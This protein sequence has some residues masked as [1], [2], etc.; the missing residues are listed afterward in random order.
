MIS[1]L[2]GPKTSKLRIAVRVREVVRKRQGE[3]KSQELELSCS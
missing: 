1:D 2:K 3:E